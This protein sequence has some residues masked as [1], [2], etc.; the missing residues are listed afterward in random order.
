M[1]TVLELVRDTVPSDWR[2]CSARC[3]TSVGRVTSRARRGA[4]RLG[5]WE[6]A[7]A[8]QLARFDGWPSSAWTARLQCRGGSSDVTSATI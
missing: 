3:Q 8:R 1:S 2:P 7:S 5:C 4:V 6:T